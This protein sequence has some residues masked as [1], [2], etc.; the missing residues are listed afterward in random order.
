MFNIIFFFLSKY[1]EKGKGENY[2]K[3]KKK[4]KNTHPHK[5]WVGKAKRGD[6]LDGCLKGQSRGGFA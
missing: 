5:L 6:A 2:I 4:K 3:L 1:K